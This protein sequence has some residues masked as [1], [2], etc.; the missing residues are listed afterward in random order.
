[1]VNLSSDEIQWKSLMK[2]KILGK[3]GEIYMVSHWLKSNKGL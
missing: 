1:M 3:K 2:L